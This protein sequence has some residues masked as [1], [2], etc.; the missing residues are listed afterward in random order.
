MTLEN[1]KNIIK[2]A[3]SCQRCE[4]DRLI[5]IS[6]HHSDSFGCWYKGQEHIGY[7][8]SIRG[9]CYNNDTEIKFCLECGQ[10]QG[11]FPVEDPDFD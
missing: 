1:I 10:I 5:N 11:E 4:S 3:N 9:V 8:P 2:K 7:A 6:A